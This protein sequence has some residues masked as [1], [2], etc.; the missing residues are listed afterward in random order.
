[1]KHRVNQ[2]TQRETALP[3]TLT[4]L[5]S[6]TSCDSQRTVAVSSCLCVLPFS[7]WWMVMSAGVG[8]IH[9]CHLSPPCLLTESCRGAKVGEQQ[10]PTLQLSQTR[11]LLFPGAHLFSMSPDTC[12]PRHTPPSA[13]SLRALKLLFVYSITPDTP[14]PSPTEKRSIMISWCNHFLST[15]TPRLCSDTSGKPRLLRPAPQ[16]SPIPL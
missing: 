12:P 9:P 4:K 16:A 3:G 2:H 10:S 1:M 14:L 5:P 6:S 8:W 11:P 13:A 7:R 15:L